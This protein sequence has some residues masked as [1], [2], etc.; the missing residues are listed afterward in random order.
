M[1]RRTSAGQR[2][3][4]WRP[5]HLDSRVDSNCLRRPST[6]PPRRCLRR[7]PAQRGRGP[8]SSADWPAPWRPCGWPAWAQR[9]SFEARPGDECRRSRRRSGVWRSLAATLAQRVYREPVAG[10]TLGLIAAGFVSFAGFLAV[11]DGPGAAQRAVGGDGGR[12]CRRA[13]SAADRL[14]AAHLHD[15]VLSCACSSPSQQRRPWQFARPLPMLGSLTTV[16]SLAL[17]EVSPRLSVTWAGLSPRLTRR[18]RL[19]NRI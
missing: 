10:L 1:L 6:T 7:S 11:P 14:W 19:R 18:S 8:G 2:D 5:A 17:I 3:P 9:C 15:A 4:Q 12:C 16:A 13:G